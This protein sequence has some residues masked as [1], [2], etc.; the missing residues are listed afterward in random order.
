MQGLILSCMILHLHRPVVGD[1]LP[2]MENIFLL[3]QILRFPMKRL[4]II[5]HFQEW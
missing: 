2:N 5:M 1:V 4:V 3:K